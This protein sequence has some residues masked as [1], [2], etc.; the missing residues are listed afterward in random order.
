MH[1]FFA[2]PI[3][4]ATTPGISV[5]FFSLSYLDVSIRLVLDLWFSKGNTEVKGSYSVLDLAPKT[6]MP[7][8]FFINKLR[9]S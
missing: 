6:F 2:L 5:D 9:I 8:P 3:S 1:L 4:F 7:R